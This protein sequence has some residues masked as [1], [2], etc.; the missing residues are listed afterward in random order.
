MD[1]A[2]STEVII[3]LKC[4]YSLDFFGFF[5]FM[6]SWLLQVCE[7]KSLFSRYMRVIGRWR[8]LVGRISTYFEL[9]T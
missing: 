9:G 4:K 3:T 5:G 8:R 7:G 2:V 6:L 1:L